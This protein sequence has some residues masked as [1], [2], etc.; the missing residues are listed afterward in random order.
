MS[1]ALSLRRV[2]DAVRDYDVLDGTRCV[3]EIRPRGFGTAELHL[4]DGRFL[5]RRDDTADMVRDGAG[6][7]PTVFRQA[8]PRARYSLRDD[9]RV[10]AR[11]ERR[12]HLSPRWDV[13][14]VWPQGEG[15]E[16]TIG[17]QGAWSGQWQAS[18]DRGAVYGITLRRGGREAAWETPAL[19][20]PV[21][22]FVLYTLHQQFGTHPSSGT[23]E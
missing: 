11:A 20:E 17:S 6:F 15:A 16:W 14:R 22:L 23:G 21:A 1:A 10:L 7:L 19:N 9:D 8:L 13:L 18:D 12:F 5:L 2:D 3:G 4:G